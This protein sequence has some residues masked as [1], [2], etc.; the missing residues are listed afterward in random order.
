MLF[1]NEIEV[2]D[3]DVDLEEDEGDDEE[4]GCDLSEEALLQKLLSFLDETESGRT[5]STGGSRTE[6]A[7][8][9]VDSIVA[10]VCPLMRDPERAAVEAV[11]PRIALLMEQVTAE[12]TTLKER[13]HLMSG[14]VRLQQVP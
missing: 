10:E 12:E 1:G 9:A 8:R 13:L 2:D 7:I 4:D 6:C 11:A 14:L 5:G 3:E